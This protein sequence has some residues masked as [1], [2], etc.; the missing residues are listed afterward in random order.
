MKPMFRKSVPLIAIFVVVTA[1]AG[2]AAT[3]ATE[4]GQATRAS[5]PTQEEHQAHHPESATP[6]PAEKMGLGSSGDQSGMMGRSAGGKPEMMGN[7]D[8]KSMCDMHNKAMQE[9][10]PEQQAEMM[11][12]HMKSMSPD[13]RRRHMEMMQEQCK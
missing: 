2:C 7:M 12:E 6:K 5:Q 4:S 13:M 1:L 3:Q 9:K 10:T 8:M 11:N